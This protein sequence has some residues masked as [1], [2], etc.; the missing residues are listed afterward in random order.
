[1]NLGHYIC[2]ASLPLLLVAT[3]WSSDQYALLLLLMKRT[4]EMLIFGIFAEK[5]K[6]KCI[7]FSHKLFFFLGM[8]CQVIEDASGLCIGRIKGWL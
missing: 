8:G 1:M 3:R 4:L 7:I 2:K 5:V 6:V